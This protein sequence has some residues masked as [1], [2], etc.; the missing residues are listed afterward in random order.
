MLGGLCVREALF[1]LAHDPEHKG[2]PRVHMPVLAT[3]LAG[4][5]L[6]DLILARRIH[7]AGGRVHALAYD[8]RDGRIPLDHAQART[9]VEE[10]AEP[11]TDHARA[12]VTGVRRPTPAQDLIEIIGLDVYGRTLTRLVET[13]HVTRTQ[14]R[15]G[16]PLHRPDQQALVE[17][18]GALISATQDIGHDPDSDALCALAHILNLHGVLSPADSAEIG[19]A[20][21][22]G[23]TRLRA[24][25]PPLDGVPKVVDTVQ[26]A[27]D[28][29]TVKV[30]A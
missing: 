29:V 4:A 22:A 27:V 24:L 14:R 12:L 26:A 8:P 18:T 9:L 2:R 13:G 1:L 28:A 23:L 11:V 25:A 20:G 21:R 30:Y 5:T 6:V 7:V 19:N 17:A 15:L 10:V 3:G 16:R